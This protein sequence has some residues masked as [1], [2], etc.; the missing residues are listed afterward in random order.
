MTDQHTPELVTRQTQPTAVIRTQT[1][2]DQLTEFYDR[3]FAAVAGVLKAQGIQAGEPFGLY[4][5]V[6]DGVVEI[7]VGFTVDGQITPE[8]DVV[9]GELPGGD[10]A[11]L[12][13]VGAYGSLPESWGQLGTWI[14]EQGRASGQTVVEVYT[15]DPTG[16]DADS[17]RTDLFW[18]VA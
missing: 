6:V 3:A 2:M 16:A 8:A 10:Y 5:P 18:S 11:H 12:T 7:E 15:D 14:K 4:G 13:H 1:R 17:L 9:A